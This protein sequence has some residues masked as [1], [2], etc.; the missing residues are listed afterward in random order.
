MQTVLPD[1]GQR[2]PSSEV[3]YFTVPVQHPEYVY[4]ACLGNTISSRRCFQNR[5]SRNGQHWR[6]VMSKFLRVPNVT[7]L[8]GISRP[9]LWRWCAAGLFPKP[10]KIGLRVSAWDSDEVQAWM[11]SQ[12]GA[13]K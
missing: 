9:T 7:A 6:F 3:S 10:Y 4:G 1:K 13:A 11:D 2:T 12:R 8:L 5:D